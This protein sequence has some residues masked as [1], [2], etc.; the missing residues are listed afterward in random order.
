[1]SD[2]MIP[3]TGFL[4]QEIQRKY[5][6]R[7]ATST[8]F[9]SLSN[10]IMEVTRESI[11]S[12]TLKRL[13]GY[14]TL[15][16]RPRASTLDILSRYLG[17]KDFN[18]FRSDIKKREI[19]GSNFFET[20]YISVN[21]LNEGDCVTIGWAPDRLVKLRYQGNFSFMVE[22][23]QNSKLEPGDR[24]EM[25]TLMIGYP[26]FIY[27]ILR[28]GEYTQSYIAGKDTGINILKIN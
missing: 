10:N 17:F 3:G 14:V 6:K 7:I 25:T 16:P 18:A 23:S 13:W 11:S 5:G 24:F 20:S 8:D 9:E 12:S 1:M 21:D 4:L 28:N 15:S 22:S 2:K 26:L 19:S 27:R